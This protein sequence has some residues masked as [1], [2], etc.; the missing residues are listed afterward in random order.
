MDTLAFGCILPATGR[1][2]DFHP[3]ER[4]P[5]GRTN[6][7]RRFHAACPAGISCLFFCCFCLQTSKG[8]GYLSA[9]LNTLMIRLRIGSYLTVTWKV[10]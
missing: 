9:D 10:V 8:F 5:A 7:N 6:E 3:L 2:R 4:A 1:I